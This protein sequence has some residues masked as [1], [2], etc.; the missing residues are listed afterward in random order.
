MFPTAEK[1]FKDWIPGIFPTDQ[2]DFRELIPG[3]FSTAEGGISE[4]LFQEYCQQ[5]NS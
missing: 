3:I 2:R 4:N 5:A 1:G